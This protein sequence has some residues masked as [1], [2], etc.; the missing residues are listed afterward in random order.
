[1]RA[2]QPTHR[3]ANLMPWSAPGIKPNRTWIYSPNES[4]LEA[5]WN[6]ITSA[7]RTEKS[8]LFRE[9]RDANLD[10]VK[11]SL[12]DPT[13]RQGPFIEEAGE[14]PPLV[15]V[16]RRAFDRQ[17]VIPDSRLMHA[18]SPSLWY[19]NGPTQVYITEQHTQP[20]TSGPALL[21]SSA[22]PDMDHFMGHHGGRVLP[23]FRSSTGALTNLTPG[24]TDLLG[25]RSAHPRPEDV[26]AYCAALAAH[27][28]YVKKF[29]EYLATDPGIR[30]PITRD[31][32]LWDE[33]VQLGREVIWLH[34]FGERFVDPR[35]GRPPG[36]PRLRAYRP[37]VL[38]EIPDA[39][40]RMP[41]SID[42][43]PVTETLYV[44]EGA[45]APVPAAVWEYEVSGRRVV[46]KWFEYRKRN[47]T[48]RR[49]SPLDNIN[50]EFWARSMTTRLL[51]LLNVLGRCV[52]LEPR[53]STL[54]DQI[55]NGPLVTY[56]DLEGAGVL[57]VPGHCRKPP[58]GTSTR[59]LWES[60]T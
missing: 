52:A 9:S 48:G 20:L 28:G 31:A 5:R 15:Q 37:K 4:V 49:S 35:A 3:G 2:A 24:L 16:A 11:P 32:A 40:E 42:H 46:K 27:A 58:K 55:L 22:I 38:T 12:F 51:E 56:E 53:Q 7:N 41:L 18:P 60:D 25:P 54:L 6:R 39:E 21:F 8:K 1:M 45:I 47:P 13:V 44:G 30:I 57:P 19:A 59:P 50:A 17:W 10:H 29:R 23:L 14:C 36:P 33:A 43:D 34:T 26:I